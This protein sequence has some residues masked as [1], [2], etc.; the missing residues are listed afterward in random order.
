MPVSPTLIT[1]STESHMQSHQHSQPLRRQIA[2]W[3]QQGDVIAFVPTMGN[4]HAGHLSL[5]ELAQRQA[6]NV[7]VV[8]SIFVNPMQFGENEDFDTYPRTLEEDVD[9]LEQMNVDMLYIP[10][11]GEIYPEG[12]DAATRVQ[13][14]PVLADV[15]EGEFRPG[16]FTGVATVV[17]RL[18]NTVQ[19]DIACFGE[20]DYQQL[21]VIRRMAADLAMPVRILCAPITREADGLAMSS[22]N[23]YLDTAQRRQAARLSH[24]LQQLVAAIRQGAGRERAL[25][26]AIKSLEKDGFSVDYVVIRRQSDLREPQ[27]GDLRLVALAAVWLGKTRLID[28]IVFEINRL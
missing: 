25:E 12:L 23:R 7:R 18:F 24:C 6:D 21:L 28:N 3:K 1:A 5:V 8:V 13:P 19:P 4:L 9:K 11:T 2:E 14:P 15:L 27:A 22:R 10:D 16:F 20:K 17:A 26:N